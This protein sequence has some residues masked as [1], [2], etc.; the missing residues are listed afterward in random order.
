[1]NVQIRTEAAQ[2]PEKEYINWD[3]R[4]SVPFVFVFARPLHI[5][6]RKYVEIINEHKPTWKQGGPELYLVAIPLA[7]HF[8]ILAYS[9]AFCHERTVMHSV[10]RE[11]P[12]IPS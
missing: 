1:M 3:F 8:Y 11:L 5:M 9:H 4:C 2:F 6:Y 10:M 12:C 7:S